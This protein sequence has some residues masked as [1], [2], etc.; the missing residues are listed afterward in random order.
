MS[1]PGECA[2]VLKSIPIDIPDRLPDEISINFRSP[3]ADCSVTIKPGVG[4][5]SPTPQPRHIQDKSNKSDDDSE[6]EIIHYNDRQSSPPEFT[7]DDIESVVDSNIEIDSSRNQQSSIFV[8]HNNSKSEDKI[9]MTQESLGGD[10]RHRSD[11]D[12]VSPLGRHFVTEE[13]FSNQEHHRR[14]VFSS[15][16]DHSSL[17]IYER[18]TTQKPMKSQSVVSPWIPTMCQTTECV[19]GIPSKDDHRHQ[20]Y[21]DNSRVGVSAP[22]AAFSNINRSSDLDSKP[23]QINISGSQQITDEII[24][25]VPNMTNQIDEKSIRNDNG[26]VSRQHETN[27]S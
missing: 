10:N 27:T 18:I 21:N 14:K 25:A 22:L 8:D 26:R 13:Q 17:T 23:K 7:L 9:N 11:Y 6:D 5:R 1:N 2:R 24:T 3:S 20:Q 16:N 15:S 19:C 4:G 12:V